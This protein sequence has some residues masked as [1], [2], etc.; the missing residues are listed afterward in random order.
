[1][2]PRSLLCLLITQPPFI[3]PPL[4]PC[5][6]PHS[7]FLLSL[8]HSTAGTPGDQGDAPEKGSEPAGRPAAATRP[9]G[10][11]CERGWGLKGEARRRTRPAAGA[12]AGRRDDARIPSS[13]RA[14]KDPSRPAA[15]AT[16]PPGEREWGL[17]GR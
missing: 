14:R 17:D 3:T 5:A 1:M 11:R 13:W 7:P 15:A 10:G 6:V 4:L 12:R 16:R 8:I 9:P 2:P